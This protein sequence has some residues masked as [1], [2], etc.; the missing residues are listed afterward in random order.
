MTA[1]IG[2][3]R[4]IIRVIA[5]LL[6]V[7]LAAGPAAAQTAKDLVGTWTIATVMAEQGET[8]FEPY[9]SN[10]EGILMFDDN[11]RYS[12]VLLRPDLP[13]FASGNRTVGTPEENRAVVQGSIAHFGTYAV[14]GGDTLLLRIEAA[15]FPN[16][17][18]AEQNRPFTLTGGK[19]EYTV[20]A[21]SGGGTGRVVWTRAK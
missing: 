12:L 19:L 15:T 1:Q 10:P 14:E 18:G 5:L 16:W 3:S 2:S 11:G 20:P 8:Q 6:G 7:T 4:V 17:N 13:R 21:A 9:G